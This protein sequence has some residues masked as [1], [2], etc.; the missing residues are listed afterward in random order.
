A[1]N[2]AVGVGAVGLLAVGLIAP[3]WMGNS[4][5]ANPA[6]TAHDLPPTLDGAVGDFG[7]EAFSR[8]EVLT[9]GVPLSYRE[10]GESDPRV[11]ASVEGADGA[12]VVTDPAGT[13]TLSVASQTEGVT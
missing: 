6:L 1:A 5:D 9:C 10:P 4:G 7:P 2:G 13:L 8:E 12:T 3:S 11:V